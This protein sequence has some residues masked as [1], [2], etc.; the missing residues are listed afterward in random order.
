MPRD[1]AGDGGRRAGDGG[2]DAAPHQVA[3]AVRAQ[4]RL[5]QGPPRR[6]RER[7]DAPNDLTRSFPAPV[8]RT[9]S[10][11]RSAGCVLQCLFLDLRRFPKTCSPD[12]RLSG[13]G[14]GEFV[15]RISD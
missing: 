4:R 1:A 12:R 7:E 13:G 15:Y 9:G 2:R 3:P 6:S 11:F 10:G 14:G 8:V 5:D